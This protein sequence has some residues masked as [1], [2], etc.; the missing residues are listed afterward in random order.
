ML[1]RLNFMLISFVVAPVALLYAAG[2]GQHS[3]KARPSANTPSFERD[4]L[5]VLNKYCV[6]CHGKNKP[7]GDVSLVGVTTEAGVV[8]ARD[9]WEQVLRNVQVGTMPPAGL[10]HPAEPERLRFLAYLE[11]VFRKLDC[12]VQ[13][14]G[15]V[16][17]RRLNREEYNNTVRDL[18]AIDLRPADDFPS[19]D[20]GYGFDNI[21]DVLSISPL[22]MEKY[23][24]SAEKI[25]RTAILAPEDVQKSEIFDGTKLSS[26]VAGN[27]PNGGRI[28]ATNGDLWIDYDFPKTGKYTVT[29][30]AFGQQAGTDLPHMVVKLDDNQIFETGVKNF[31]RNPGTFP[32]TATIATK[33]K[34][35]ISVGF[36]NDFYDPTAKNVN[37]RDRNLIINR[38]ELKCEETGLPEELPLSHRRILFTSYK[39]RN[40][41]EVA[42][43]L[44][45]VFAGRAFRRPATERELSRLVKY[46]TVAEEQGESFERGMQLAV[47]ATLCS[48]YFLFRVE[49]PAPANAKGSVDL[50]NYEIASR[51]SYYLW[52]SMP[53]AELFS[54]ASKGLLTNPEELAHQARRM[55]KDPK[56]KALT[57]NFAGQWLQLRKLALIN[58]DSSM[59]P[60]F[61]PQ[62]RQ[63]MKRETE[64]FFE[65]V[66]N[67]DRSIIDFLDGRFTF[68]DSELAKFYG[69][70]NIDDKEF[71]RVQLAGDQ[72]MGVLTHASILTVTSNPTRTSPVKR[73]KWILENILGTPPPPPLP[74]VGKL[75]DDD[76]KDGKPLLGT[77][78]QRMEQHRKNAI[79]ASC[80]SRMDPI[81][82]GLENFNAVGQWREKD[83]TD[84]I[85]SSGT[86]PGGQSFKGPVQLIK[87][88][89]TKQSLFV[90]NFAEKMLTYALGRG[91]ERTDR[92]HVEAVMKAAQKQNYRFSAVVTAIV[93][94]DAFR[95]RRTG[96]A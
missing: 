65:S 53:D 11:S 20:V 90:H 14:P 69:L 70:P 88:L 46:V 43:E 57:Q 33:G 92:C 79:C 89:K 2:I 44:L 73:G 32:V 39:D 23:I 67:E 77:L 6:S 78:R 38:L 13:D 54:V 48:P 22:L 40:R 76:K 29:I 28:L 18:L 56:S 94:S 4:V 49:Q 27:Y 91:L 95:K 86:L 64:L 55:L 1:A 10:P 41:K 31:E 3:T 63:S 12:R 24:A 72:R 80:H 51:L 5:P 25:S 37:R 83:G 21:G 16:T 68:V 62:L 71:H 66:V 82:F 36:T 50:S 35:R 74:N 9:R 58:P 75:A 42:H 15:R 34:H 96:G 87:I 47:Q 52:S 7:A 85:D 19:D 93:Q 81:G 17:M 59:F 8:A 30:D 84:N 60:A 45:K 26:L 61:T